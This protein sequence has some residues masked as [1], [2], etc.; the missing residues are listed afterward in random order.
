MAH[1]QPTYFLSHCYSCIQDQKQPSA[2]VSCPTSEN[3]QQVYEGHHSK[4]RVDQKGFSWNQLPVNIREQP[5]LEFSRNC[6]KGPWV[7]LLC[8]ELGGNALD[9]SPYIYLHLYIFQHQILGTIKTRLTRN[10]PG[11]RKSYIFSN[12]EPTR[13]QEVIHFFQAGKNILLVYFMFHCI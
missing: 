6:L 9:A 7:F 13:N 4:P 2:I 12:Q 3:G 10:L 1:C 5:K 8:H 11:T